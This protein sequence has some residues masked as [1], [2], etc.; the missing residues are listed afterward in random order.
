VIFVDFL[1]NETLAI[2]LK[3]CKD[4][5]AV[6]GV[7]KKH[8]FKFKYEAEHRCYTCNPRHLFQIEDE[9]LFWDEISYGDNTREDIYDFAFP[10]FTPSLRRVR[11]DVNTLKFKPLIPEQ[12]EA[13]NFILRRDAAI[14]DSDV[15]TGKTFMSLGVLISRLK[16]GSI[17]KIIFLTV[18]SVMYS[19][20]YE[21]FKFTD[22]FQEDEVQ[23]VLSSNK[24][25]FDPK[26][27]MLIMSHDT[28]RI[29][30]SYYHTKVTK[31]VPKSPKVSHLP[32]EE[33]VGS[34]SGCFLC[35]DEAHKIKNH[36]SLRHKF[37]KASMPKF[38][39][40]LAMS[41][42]LAPKSFSD[43]WG[44]VHLFFHELFYNMPFSEW[45]EDTFDLDKHGSIDKIKPRKK[46][47]YINRLQQVVY[48]LSKDLLKLPG[49]V[50]KNIIIPP[51]KKLYDIYQAITTEELTKV[52]QT[53]EGATEVSITKAKYFAYSLV[54]DPSL[55][56]DK[57]VRSSVQKLLDSWS[58]E[59]DNQKIGY[60]K[61]IMSEELEDDKDTKFIIWANN[62]AVID[63]LSE[64]FKDMNP[65]VIHGQ[66]TP[67]GKEPYAWRNEQIEAFKHNKKHKLLIGNPPTLGVGL[68]ITEA[69]VVFQWSRPDDYEAVSQSLGRTNRPGMK[70]IC[71]VY[72]LIYDKTIELAIDESLS[73]KGDT[74]ICLRSNRPEGSK[75]L[76]KS[77]ISWIF[78]GRRL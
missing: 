26:A 3:D 27:K 50:Q 2:R 22:Y 40:Y 21:V 1:E 60:V 13:I 28:F 52:I 17:N 44:Y 34:G 12:E 8:K 36:S 73:E 55:V 69:R 49:E 39:S 7:L 46:R 19:F 62:P 31:K 59:K 29:I 77:D 42:T 56:K 25:C 72:N 20:R 51:S 41:G 54:A 45:K 18:P 33:W 78:T 35:I 4:F 48:S 14:L 70:T 43:F 57:I 6:H 66:N 53:S 24:E 10:D 71:K 30:T 63:K 64:I 5:Q 65:I 16:E 61:Q 37:L 76:T 74:N 15:G 9:L 32:I 11:Y 75:K 67:S 58:F 68:N 23:I 47:V 38:I